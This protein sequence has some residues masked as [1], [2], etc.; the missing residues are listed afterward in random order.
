MGTSKLKFCGS[1][2][3]VLHI[4][5]YYISGASRKCIWLH[6][7]KHEIQEFKPA[8][9]GIWNVVK[10]CFK[11]N[12]KFLIR[13]ATC[14]ACE[15]CFNQ[16]R[17]PK[18]V[19]LEQWRRNSKEALMF[20]FLLAWDHCSDTSTREWL[21]DPS[22]QV[23]SWYIMSSD[24][25]LHTNMCYDAGHLLVAP[26]ATYEQLKMHRMQNRRQENSPEHSVIRA[27]WN[28]PPL[29]LLLRHFL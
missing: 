10:S 18:V 4:Y 23:L 6:N 20:L 22:R 13:Q 1:V 14:C 17:T 12:I 24:S 2:I 11:R 21:I 5:I 3:L 26:S 8:Q 28:F 29:K 9:K 27:E 16:L 19:Y 7:F 25:W 15:H